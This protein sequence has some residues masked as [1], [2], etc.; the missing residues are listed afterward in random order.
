MAQLGWF[1]AGTAVGLFAGVLLIS[2]ARVAHTTTEA[3]ER[4]YLPSTPL[5]PKDARPTIV[6]K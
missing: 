3:E 2:L 1:L 6:R 4:E 5:P